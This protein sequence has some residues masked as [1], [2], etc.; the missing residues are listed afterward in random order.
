MHDDCQ[1]TVSACPHYS[2]GRGHARHHLSGQQA[3]KSAGKFP[4]ARSRDGVDDHLRS[5]LSQMA[6]L[7]VK[8]MAMVMLLLKVLVMAVCMADEASVG[9]VVGACVML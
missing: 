2:F 1:C 4:L 8:A 7:L 3:V 9:V 5:L 6:M